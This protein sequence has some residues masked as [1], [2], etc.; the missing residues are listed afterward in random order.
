MK[1]LVKFSIL[2]RFPSY[3]SKGS[4]LAVGKDFLNRT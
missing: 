1:E 3:H 2:L 4:Y